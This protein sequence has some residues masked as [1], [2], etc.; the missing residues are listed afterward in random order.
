MEVTTSI[1]QMKMALNQSNLFVEEIKLSTND[2][3]ERI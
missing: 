2:K 1:T 3:L